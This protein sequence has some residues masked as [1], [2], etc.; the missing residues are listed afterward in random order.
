MMDVKMESDN[1]D[2]DMKIVP[3]ETD[4][5]SLNIALKERGAFLIK[6]PSFLAD[7]WRQVGNSPSNETNDVILG[8]LYVIGDKKPGELKPPLEMSL[9]DVEMYSGIPKSYSFRWAQKADRTTYAFV[10][11]TPGGIP[12]FFQ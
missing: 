5:D 6:V 3:L 10:E 11:K 7:R 9:P 1:N 12:L 2:T 4:D 8:A